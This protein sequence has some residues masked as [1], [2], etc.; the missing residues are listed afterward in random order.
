MAT[1]GQIIGV[2]KLITPGGAPGPKG[3]PGSAIPLADN[4]QNGLLKQVSGNVTDYVGGDNVCHPLAALNTFVTKT[5]AYTLSPA[6]S[7]KYIICSGGSW[8]LTLPI[9]VVGLTYRLRNDMGI[10]GTTGTITVQPTGGTIDGKASLAL[11]PQQEC[12]IITDGTNWR[13]FEL[14]RE[15]ILG[16]LDITSVASGVILLPVGY[17]YF[18]IEFQNFGVSASDYLGGQFSIDGGT[19]WQT[20][21]YYQGLMYN[22]SATVTT[23]QNS[24][25]IAQFYIL[26]TLSSANSNWGT[27][28]L[29]ISP[30]AVIAFRV[31][32][33]GRTSAPMQYQWHNEGF[34]NNAAVPNALKVFCPGGANI[35]LLKSTVKGVV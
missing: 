34:W 15:V 6:D 9:P 23:Y 16:T 13:T 22:N 28:R 31:D 1:P 33:I 5:A 27:G 21:N 10:S 29:V 35:A 20:T 11:L 7:S 19:T 32:S 8:T 26:P 4:T 3:D 30:G 24:E 14:R 18:E 12:T 25:N 17:R 2:G